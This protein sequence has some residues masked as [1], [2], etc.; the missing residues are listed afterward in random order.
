[1]LTLTEQLRELRIQID[2]LVRASGSTL[3]L[4]GSLGT[5]IRDL[6][7]GA[8]KFEFV[9]TNDLGGIHTLIAML[10]L[11]WPNLDRHGDLQARHTPSLE[12]ARA[13][14]QLA[15]AIVQWGREGQIVKR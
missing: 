12:E 4:L 14:V 9:L 15:V 6:R 3:R 11:M 1:M 13:V 10:Q 5:L 7:N 2:A 8:H